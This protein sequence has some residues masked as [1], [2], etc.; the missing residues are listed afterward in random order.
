M[1]NEIQKYSE[2]IQA[3]CIQHNVKTLFAFGS[4]LSDKFN[5]KS[6]IDLI[7]DIADN[8]PFTY[9]DNYFDLKFKLENLFNRPVDLLENKALKNPYLKK[10]IDT[11]KVLV[12]GK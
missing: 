6:D 12:Y 2:Q 8:D 10:E 1:Q 7:V 4:V 3:L 9:T 11:T 5:S